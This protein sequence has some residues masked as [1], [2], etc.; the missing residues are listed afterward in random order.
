MRLEGQAVPQIRTTKTE[1]LFPRFTTI[2]KPIDGR[3]W[4]PVYTYADDTLEFR[5][6]ATHP[7]E[8]R[9]RQLQAL[10]RGIDVYTAIGRPTGRPRAAACILL[11]PGEQ[12]FGYH[13]A[14]SG[15][16]VGVEGPA[17]I[18][19]CMELHTVGTLVS[20]AEMARERVS[21]VLESSTRSPTLP[22]AAV[23][24]WT[25]WLRFGFWASW[26]RPD[27]AGVAPVRFR[28]LIL[29]RRAKRWLV[30]L[31]AGSLRLYSNSCKK[32]RRLA[33][34]VVFGESRAC[35]SRP[36]RGPRGSS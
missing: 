17:L 22:V 5:T 27:S 33:L 15:F 13:A 20:N 2:R 10:R 18:L 30:Y 21:R 11:T 14:G 35:R 4:F 7:L 19:H 29:I 28:S 12:S 16:G 1:N 25:P 3:H 36:A 9:V 31:S 24:F 34:Q 32:F 26:A 8:N 6:G 23:S